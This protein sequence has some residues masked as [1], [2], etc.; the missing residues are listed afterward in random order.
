MD[1]R[2]GSA[3]EPT[4]EWL[5][6]G[7][8]TNLF[9]LRLSH[10]GRCRLCSSERLLLVGTGTMMKG[11]GARSEGHLFIKYNH[12]NRNYT[13]YGLFPDSQCS[14]AP[15]SPAGRG[16]DG[17][18]CLTERRSCCQPQSSS[19]CR[20]KPIPRLSRA[21]SLSSSSN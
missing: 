11:R 18:L 14:P 19:A 5:R 16:S 9:G 15:F 10:R 17:P 13:G 20:P 21:L 2:D 8:R 6:H 4:T 7:L 12:N 1:V 3:R